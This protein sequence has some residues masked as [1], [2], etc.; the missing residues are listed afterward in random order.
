MKRGEPCASDPT[1]S[2]LEKI[3]ER[4][5][6]RL[7]ARLDDRE[8]PKRHRVEREEAINEPSSN[9]PRRPGSQRN[10]L[11]RGTAE[12]QGTVPM[13]VFVA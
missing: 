2:L 9:V 11:D 6:D 5:L 1:G 13:S 7:M 8:R 12:K 4:L 3:E 10:D